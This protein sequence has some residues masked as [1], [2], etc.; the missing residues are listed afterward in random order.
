MQNNIIWEG[1]NSESLENCNVLTKDD[2]VQ[3][4]STISLS[5][6]DKICDVEYFIQADKNW[7]SQYCKI[8]NYDE[9][10]TVKTLELERMKNNRWKI[11]GEHNP[12]FDGFD[13][14]DVSVTPFTNSLI[15]NR[16]S[17]EQ[18]ES[19]ELKMIYIDALKLA[20]QPIDVRYTKLSD[21][22]YEYENRTTGYNVVLDVDE[23]G[24]VDNYPRM[25]KKIS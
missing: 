6:K 17:M 7:R 19:F 8:L 12:A 21:R 9:N 1:Y 16:K 20:C 13:A 18:E 2:G 11:N 25:F 10:R 4:N 24:F 23:N 15:I 14:I 22:E 5:L 3:V